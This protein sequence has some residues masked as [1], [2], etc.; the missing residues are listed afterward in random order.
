MIFVE[1]LLGHAQILAHLAALLPRH[2]GQPVEVI[3]HDRAF[4]RHRRHV[5]Q[6]VELGL[7]F[8]EHFLRHAGVVDLLG[9][10][11]DLVAALV[12]V[13]QFFLDRLHLLVEV[14]LALAL[15]HLRLDAPAN[16]LL[17][18][19]QV[20]FTFH[21]THQHFRA[22]AHRERVQHL[23]LVGQAHGKMRCDRIG[24][25][26]KIVDAGKSGQHFRRQLA[27]LAHQLLEQV[28]QH[29]RGG[30][31]FDG[32]TIEHRLQRHH[33]RAQHAI[34][35]E[36][37]VQLAARLAFHQH[38][39]RAVRQLHQLQHAADGADR[40][41]VGLARIVGFG[42]LLRDQQDAAVAFHRGFQCFHR[43][44][45]ADEQRDHHVRIHH[46]VAQRQ[47][48]QFKSRG[49]G[50][51][52]FG[53][54]FDSGFVMLRP[55]NAGNGKRMV[56]RGAGIKLKERFRTHGARLAFVSAKG[57]VRS[58][59]KQLASSCH[60]HTTCAQ[61]GPLEHGER[62]RR[63]VQRMAHRRCASSP[64]AQGCACGEPRRLLAQPE[65]MDVLR[66]VRGVAFL[67]VTSLWPSKEK[68]PARPG[69]ARKKT[70]RRIR[71]PREWRSR[72]AS[73]SALRARS[74][75]SGDG[76][77]CQ[78][79]ICFCRC[80]RRSCASSESVAIGRASRRSRPISSSVSS[81]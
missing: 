26:R 32:R 39:D 1:H 33:V 64:Q 5:L 72:V 80:S 42:L 36:A 27:A 81:Q 15:L 49:Q 46:H 2:A 31:Q 65:H 78:S 70:G 54:H 35:F 12:H 24:E 50:F 79:P 20:E 30:F 7:G 10:R 59:R 14:I 3:A 61:S 28:H 74:P 34:G 60:A 52:G 40:M 6:L 69:G 21:Q 18:L 48:G 56:A 67:L 17:D 51:F 53:C 8:R 71:A 44:V 4:R 29:A 77:V 37:T 57:L 9:Q 23:L 43:L 13:A 68:S 58:E 22:R 25:A 11:V 19:L 62:G 45:A 41:Q 38:L 55:A 76:V 47:H 66:R 63:T 75:A 16:A 73:P